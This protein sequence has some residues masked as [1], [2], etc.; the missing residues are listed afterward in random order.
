MTLDEFKVMMDDVAKKFM[1]QVC[2]LT[3]PLP[4]KGQIELFFSAFTTYMAESVALEYQK[5]IQKCS[6]E[7]LNLPEGS[8]AARILVA[9][10][11]LAN[12]LGSKEAAN[13]ELNRRLDERFPI[14]KVPAAED[15]EL[16]NTDPKD[17]LN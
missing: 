4:T 14:P 10:E 16:P 5:I 7:V 9:V 13:T 8:S 1:E 11:D 6:A 15:T 2:E 17:F 12:E 3:C